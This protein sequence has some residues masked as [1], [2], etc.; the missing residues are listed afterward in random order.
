MSSIAVVESPAG[1]NHIDYMVVLLSNVLYKNSA[2]AHQTLATRIHRL[3]EAL[4]PQPTFTDDGLPVAENFGEHLIDYAEK[5]Q[6]R[7]K[8]VSVQA[9]LTKL[10][11][12]TGGIDG[13][14]GPKTRRAIKK[15]QSEHD[16]KVDG[17]VSDALL[18]RLNAALN[19][20]LPRPYPAQ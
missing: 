19:A 6:Q 10:G 16:I 17:K 14:I 15:F 3:I 11:Y 9:A 20:G 12:A 13:K 1:Q 5:R 7:Q 8:I 18:E 4:H 2:V